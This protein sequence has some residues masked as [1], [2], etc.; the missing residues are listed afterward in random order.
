MAKYTFTA[1]STRRIADTVQ[2]VEGM[3]RDLRRIDN[4]PGEEELF[5]FWAKITDIDDG[6]HF[7]AMLELDPE[8]RQLVT[9]DPAITGSNAYEVNATDTTMVDDIVWMWWTGYDVDDNAIYNFY[10]HPGPVQPDLPV[11]I[12]DIFEGSETADDD[13][14]TDIQEEGGIELYVTTR[15]VYNEEGDKTLYGFKRM[16]TFDERGHLKAVTPEIRYTID[17][18]VPCDDEY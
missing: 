12:G 8:T 10:N 5:G 13:S 18:A 9:R 15:V 16:L 11:S 1:D 17:A 7:W 14:V 2:R 4:P 3:R 6:N